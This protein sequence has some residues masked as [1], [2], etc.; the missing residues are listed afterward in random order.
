MNRLNAS[1]SDGVK[2][3]GT[4]PPVLPG[5]EA[6]NRYWDKTRGKYAAK[7]NPG[8]FYV[9]KANELIA[10]V[11][12]SCVASCIRDPVRGI[13]GMNHFMLP[14]SGSQTF[15]NGADLSSATRYGNY[16]M[17]HLINTI[18]RYGGKRDKLELKVFGGGKVLAQLTNIGA[19]NIEFVHEYIRIEGFN[20]VAEDT[21]GIHPRKV[22]YDPVSGKVNVRKL[23]SIHNS[24]IEAR[25]VSYRDQL[26]TLKVEG[27]VDLF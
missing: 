1:A 9:T 19:R 24:T 27:E 20:V 2:P 25:E 5:F 4:P 6:I 21:G 12:G 8:E 10:T 26:A 7:I 23:K 17:E 22:I 14:A 18:L 13:G 11:L 16:A 15:G 3:I